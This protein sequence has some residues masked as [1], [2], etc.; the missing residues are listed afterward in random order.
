MNNTRRKQLSEFKKVIDDLIADITAIQS[1]EENYRDNIPENLQNSENYTASE[2]A[3]SEMQ[4]ALDSLDN[5]SMSL[6]AAQ[7]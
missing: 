7:E 4:D 6:Q 3:L 1:D 5:A 2:S